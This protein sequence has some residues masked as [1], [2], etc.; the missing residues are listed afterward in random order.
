MYQQTILK[1]A[2]HLFLPQVFF[3]FLEIHVLAVATMP[4]ALFV[5]VS[6]ELDSLSISNSNKF[7]NLSII[8]DKIL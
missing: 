6:G 7:R 5:R 1:T 3:F 4:V 8:T 2:F